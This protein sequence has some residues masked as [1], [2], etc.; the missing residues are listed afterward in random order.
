MS[1]A[2]LLLRGFGLTGG[3]TPPTPI[4][5]AQPSLLHAPSDVVRHLIVNIGIGSL[6]S[7]N[8][9]WPVWE[10][11][12][13]DMPDNA[14]TVYTTSGQLMGRLQANGR[15]P[16]QYGIQFRVR[17]NSPNAAYQKISIIEATVDQTI[18]ENT[19]TIDNVTYIVLGINRKGGVMSLGK[20]PTTKR[21]IYT[22]NA[23]ANIQR[24]SSS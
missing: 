3:P 22:L 1:L 8:L 13:N 7:S 15:I 10:S 16:Q 23:V 5:P 12:E 11:Y 21:H 19:V 14:I 2:G 9:D 17:A 20:E 24:H 4:G 18:L 6:P